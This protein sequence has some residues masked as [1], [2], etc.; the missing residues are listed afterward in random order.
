M[1]TIVFERALDYR[2][3][4]ENKNVVGRYQQSQA[5]LKHAEETLQNIEVCC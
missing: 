4:L 2:S 5:Y 3:G 1:L